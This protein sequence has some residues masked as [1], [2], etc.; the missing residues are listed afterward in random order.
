MDDLKHP[1]LE[2]ELGST[3]VHSTPNGSLGAG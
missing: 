1:Q 3:A 2:A